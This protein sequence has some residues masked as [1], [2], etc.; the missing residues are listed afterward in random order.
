MNNPYFKPGASSL[1]GSWVAIHK[2]TG[3]VVAEVWPDQLHR[4]NFKAFKLVTIMRYLQD[5]NK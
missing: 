2:A 4:V 3:K 5:L 1:I